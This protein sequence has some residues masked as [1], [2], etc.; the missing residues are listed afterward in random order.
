VRTDGARRLGGRRKAGG[1][2]RR[3]HRTTKDIDL[4]VDPAPEN[5]ARL[6]QA[7]SVL[8][9]DAAKEPTSTDVPSGATSN[10]SIL[11]GTS[12]PVTAWGG[13]KRQS[14]AERSVVETTRSLLT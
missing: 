11:P 7:L 4:L 5:I 10:E 13:S 3:G 9:E 14:E 2:R 8:E 6:K 1:W 12:D